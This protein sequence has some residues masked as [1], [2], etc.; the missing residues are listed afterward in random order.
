M[1]KRIWDRTCL[2]VGDRHGSISLIIAGLGSVR[3]VDRN[4][5]EVCSEAVTVSVV[6]GEQSSL[7]HL[8]WAARKCF[9]QIN[10]ATLSLA[11]VQFLGQGVLERRQVVPLRQNSCEDFCSK[12]FFRLVA[13][14][15]HSAAKPWSG[16]K[17]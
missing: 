12:L 8:V 13:A 9:N 11:S 3:T 7:Q 5:K 15:T 17:D 4:L 1:K 16:Q 10:I 2:I 6:V 14:G